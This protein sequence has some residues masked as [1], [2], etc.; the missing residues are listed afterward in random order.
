M[1]VLVYSLAI[2]RMYSSYSGVTSELSYCVLSDHHPSSILFATVYYASSMGF[3]SLTLF[4]FIQVVI[5]SWD[6][7]STFHP[8]VVLW[9]S[10]TWHSHRVSLVSW[11]GCIVLFMPHCLSGSQYLPT[12]IIN[13]WVEVCCNSVGKHPVCRA[14]LQFYLIFPYVKGW[15][16][17]SSPH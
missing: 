4:M 13:L 17:G 16:V 1:V 5:P 11:Y 2:L 10:V 8:R 3:A 15:I 9:F 7:T 14:I 6:S 12:L